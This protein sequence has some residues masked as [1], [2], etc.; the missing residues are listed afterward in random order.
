MVRRISILGA[1]A[2]GLVAAMALSACSRS[3]PYAAGGW[4]GPGPGMMGPGMMGAYG[5][6]MMGPGYAGCWGGGMMAGRGSGYNQQPLNLTANDVKTN[7]ERWIAITGNPRLKLGPVA[8][9]DANT[10]T[11]DIVTLD[12][13]LVQRLAFDRR[14]GFA[15]P[16]Q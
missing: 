1:F 16:A 3:Q 2:V 7:V 11:A 8:Q 5:P 15:S 10:I 6:G 13:S 4:W 9:K 14:T 12:N